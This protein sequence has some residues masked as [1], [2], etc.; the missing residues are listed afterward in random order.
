MAATVDHISGG[1]AVLG[2]GA[3]WQE[4][5]HVAYGIEFPPLGERMDCLEEAAAIIKG[6]FADERTDFAGRH[7]EVIAAPLA[8]KPIQSPLPLLIGGG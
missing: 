3:G 1:R 2:L 5:E 4:N 8:P 6:L 7:Y